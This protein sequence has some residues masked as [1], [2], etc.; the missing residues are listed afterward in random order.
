[1][2]IYGIEINNGWKKF[3]TVLFYIY[4]NYMFYVKKN[5]KYAQKIIKITQTWNIFMKFVY[6]V[7]IKMLTGMKENK[8]D[9]KLVILA[10]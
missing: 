7:T 2:D 8:W 5:V 10:K 1:M 9:Y 4:G 3:K 6:N